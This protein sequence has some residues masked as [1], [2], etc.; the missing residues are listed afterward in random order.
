M[1]CPCT[2]VFVN[3]S[4]AAE[5]Q[6]GVAHYLLFFIVN[7]LIRTNKKNMWMMCHLSYHFEMQFGF[8]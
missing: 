7:L 3:P 4:L 1:A 8:Y 5:I 2:T 6:C